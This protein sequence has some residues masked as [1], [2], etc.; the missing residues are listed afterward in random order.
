M[1]TKPNWVLASMTPC[2]RTSAG[3]ARVRTSL[4]RCGARALSLGG[5][6][7][8]AAIAPG[9]M[10]R[11]TLPGLLVTPDTAPAIALRRR[12]PS[13]PPAVAPAPGDGAVPRTHL[14]RRLTAARAIP[15]VLIV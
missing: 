6:A 15:I 1:R 12:R 5:H 11:P 7:S 13:A 10:L 9:V 3:A 2:Q 8:L 14:L 4:S